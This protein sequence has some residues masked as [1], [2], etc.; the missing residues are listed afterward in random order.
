MGKFLA[1][2]SSSSS[3][4]QAPLTLSQ[5][6][7]R[8][9]EDF[10]RL[11]QAPSIFLQQRQQQHNKATLLPFFPPQPPNHCYQ[12]LKPSNTSL[13]KHLILILN[14]NVSTTNS[15]SHHLSP[16]F[17][18]PPLLRFSSSLNTNNINKLNKSFHISC[19]KKN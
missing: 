10:I 12:T 4:C 15:N 13:L 8:R 19:W 17:L 3:S 11:H 16:L 14:K 18:L 7:S 6:V 5:N 1:T 9:L 2:S